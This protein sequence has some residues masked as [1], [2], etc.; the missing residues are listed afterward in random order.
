MENYICRKCIDSVLFLLDMEIKENVQNVKKMIGSIF[1]D[2][3]IFSKNEKT[4]HYL[5]TVQSKKQE[6]IYRMDRVYNKGLEN[7]EEHVR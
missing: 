5:W 1:F 3:L 6:I 2:E 4:W 7:L